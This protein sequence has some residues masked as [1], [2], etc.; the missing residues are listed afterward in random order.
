MAGFLREYSIEI[1]NS[2]DTHKQFCFFHITG[3]TRRESDVDDLASV[4]SLKPWLPAT[5]D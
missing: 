1:I 3:T 2:T 4:T 5:E